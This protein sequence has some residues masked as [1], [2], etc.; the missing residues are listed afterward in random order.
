MQEHRTLVSDSSHAWFTST[1]SLPEVRFKDHGLELIEVIDNGTGI[2]PADYESVGED[3]TSGIRYG[4]VSCALAL[5]HYT[6]KLDTFDDLSTVST[7]GFRGEALSSL[8]ALSDGV[9][10]VTATA[11]EAPMGTILEIDRSGKLKNRNGKVARQVRY[12]F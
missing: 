5:K 11:S 9:T 8:C 3:P 12:S 2:A 6:S 7:F 4:T 10:V 1:H